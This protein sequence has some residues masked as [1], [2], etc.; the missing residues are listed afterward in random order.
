MA[1]S[2]LVSADANDFAGRKYQLIYSDPPWPYYGDQSR[3]QAC[4]KHYDMMSMD[5]LRALP[6]PKMLDKR[7]WV[8]MWVTGPRFDLGIDLLR[9]WGLHFRG[10]PYVWIKTRRDGKIIGG[11][12]SRPSHVKSLCE[13]VIAG[14]THSKG[15][16]LP[17]ETERQ[18][19][20]V[21][22]ED[23]GDLL[24]HPED[25]RAARPGNRHSAKPPEVRRRIEELFGPV[26]RLEMFAREAAPGWDA[27]GNQ[28]E[29][30]S[31]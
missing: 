21:S 25:I 5:D 7:A 4:G 1:P 20:V 15:R 10:V 29:R 8:F 16:I 30:S 22:D 9:A 2:S 12:G 14:G 13:F 19:Q 6:V 17:I 31:P 26:R 3:P 23:L 27:F 24:L 11:Q 18:H 28:I